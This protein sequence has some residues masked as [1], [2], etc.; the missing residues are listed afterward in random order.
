[1]K[2]FLAIFTSLVIAVCAVCADEATLFDSSVKA[3]VLETG[4]DWVSNAEVVGVSGIYQP[5]RN[6][7]NPIVSEKYGLCVRADNVPTDKPSRYAI[8]FVD[9]TFNEP[10]VG[11]G[12]IKNVGSIKSMDITVTLNRGYDEVEVY[13]EQN[14]VERVRR[15]KASDS[16][17]TVT[18]MVEFTAHIDFSDYIDD[19]RNRDVSQIPLAGIN[20]PDIKLKRI[21]VLTNPASNGWAFGNTSIVG[22]KKITVV[23]DKAVTDED[24]EQSLEMDELFGKDVLLDQKKKLTKEIEAKLRQTEYNKSL[25]AE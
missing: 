5:G 16:D 25:M 19:V 4:Y 21:E 15:F 23:Y 18:S 9:A 17:A 10:N 13:W 20:R 1:M 24:Y 12:I 11:A 7:Y 14:G 6:L 3:D 8:K 22:V 2:R